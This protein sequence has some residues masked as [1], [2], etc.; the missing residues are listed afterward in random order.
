[1]QAPL[2]EIRERKVEGKSFSGVL[3]KMKGGSQ[4]NWYY[5]VISIALSVGI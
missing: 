3:G 5:T 1:M 2:E 4:Y